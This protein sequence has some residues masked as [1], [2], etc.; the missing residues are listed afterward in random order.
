MF[1]PGAGGFPVQ[2]NTD[3]F[4]ALPTEQ[5]FTYAAVPQV[6]GTATSPQPGISPQV[7][8]WFQAVDR[9]HSGKI[10]WQELQSAL[11]NAQGQNFSETACRLMIG[12]FDRDK[13]GS[14]DITEFSQLYIY[15][16]QWLSV[17]RNYDRDQSGNI[18]EAELTQAFQQMGFRFTPQFI[19]FL[20]ERSDPKTHNR[21]S[22]DQFIVVCV[23]IQRFTEAFRSRDLNQQG[24]ITIQFED[25][26]NVALSCSV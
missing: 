25:F 20:I 4:P 23:Q 7:Q 12:M 26:L 24:Q 1:N 10:N 5:P 13:S 16:T 6:Y 11:V 15:I 8:Q 21:M 14:I 18:E 2:V 9:D 19:R 3:T 22:V 17:F